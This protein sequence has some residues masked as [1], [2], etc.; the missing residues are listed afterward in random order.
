MAL[1]F[2]GKKKQETMPT[3]TTSAPIDNAEDFFKDMGR[4][5]KQP[6]GFIDVEPPIISG[7][8]DE[9]LPPPGSTIKNAE[10][11][12]TA[13]LRDKSNDAPDPMHARIN[14]IKEEIN[15]DVIPKEEKIYREPNFGG[16]SADDFFRDLDRKK[17]AK[18]VEIDVPEV[19]GLREHPVEHTQA[20]IGGA[21]DDEAAVEAAVEALK[22]KTTE[23]G[24][25]VH[26]DI[27]TVDLS[28]ID[29]SSL[30]PEK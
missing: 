17:P 26:G 10:E 24:D 22:D 27:N 5:R 6:T 13:S 12:E 19:T 16:I 2:F 25:F 29:L 9:P 15:T 7:L 23:T 28:A 30:R 21:D 11:V 14:A 4:K 3:N 18:A 8:H 20:Q 1:S